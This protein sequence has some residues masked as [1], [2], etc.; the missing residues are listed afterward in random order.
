MNKSI[1]YGI[2]VAFW[3]GWLAD[4]LLKEWINRPENRGA[5]IL[6]GFLLL[7]MVEG[8]GWFLAR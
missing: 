3:L 5:A 1:A 8:V 4:S 2:P 7:T 6:V